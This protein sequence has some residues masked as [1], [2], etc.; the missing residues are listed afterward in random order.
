[1]KHGDLWKQFV[2]PDNAYRMA[3]LMRVNDAVTREEALR[4]V[5]SLKKQGCGGLFTYCEHLADQAPFRFLSQQWWAAVKVFAEACVKEGL[6]FWAYDEQDWPSGT[7]GGQLVEQNPEMGWKYVCPTEQD[8]EGPT[9]ARIEIGDGTLVAALAFRLDGEAVIEGSVRDLAEQVQSRLLTWNVPA[10]RWRVAVYTQH[11]GQGGALV[12]FS[13]DLMDPV[14][15]R[16]FIGMSYKGYLEAVRRVRG[17]RIAGYFTDEPIFSMGLYPTQRY[18]PTRPATAL[19]WTPGLLDA[20]RAQHGYDL[21]PKLPYLYYGGK[22]AVPTRCHYFQTCSRL[23]CENYFGQIYRFCEETGTLAT[24]HLNGEEV[25]ALH[26]GS[27]G[28]NHLMHYRYMHI[29]GIDWI[30]PRSIPLPSV[31]PK[32]AASIAHLMGRDRT[33][34]ESFAGSGW[35]M[36]FQEMRGIVNWE[37]VNGINM[38]IPISYKYSLRG[39]QRTTFYNPGISYQQPYWDHFRAFAD[40]EARLCAITAGGGHVAQVAL[41]YPAADMQAHF[42]ESDLLNQRSKDYNDLGDR[43]R[44]AGYDFDILDDHIVLEETGVE[45]GCLETA[46]ESFEVLVVPQM[47]AFRRATLEKVRGFVLAGGTLLFVG[48]LPRHSVESGADDPDLLRLLVELLSDNCHGRMAA[49]D[50]RWHTCGAGRV[51]MAPDADGAVTLLRA[52]VTPDVQMTPQIPGIVASHRRLDDGDLYL[53]HNH[54]DQPCAVRLTLAAKGHPERWDPLTGEAEGIDGYEVGDNGT[55]L[56]LDLQAQELVPVFLHADPAQAKPTTTATLLQAIPVPGPFRFRIEET[57]W[58]PEIAWNFSDVQREWTSNAEPLDVPES[59]GAGDWCECGLRCFSGIGHY[60]TE[61]TLEAMPAGTRVVLS[62][63]RVGVSAE[64]SV[65]GKRAGF[66]LFDPYEIDITDRVTEG[67]NRLTI[68]VANTLAN[69]YSQFAELAG[70]EHFEG[71]VLPEHLA[72]GLIGPVSLKM[73]ERRRPAGLL[74]RPPSPVE[75]ESLAVPLDDRLGLDD[76]Q[77]RSPSR[78]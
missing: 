61:V 23:F 67:R 16:T 11:L 72:S 53:V 10:G 7:C 58:R 25:F 52:L 71:G 47:D 36:T 70:K 37:H 26:L 66:V 64:V 51:G 65:N 44:Y 63:G 6:D 38:Q 39:P 31:S 20:F 57:L 19:A 27:Q 41:F 34:C 69:Y 14:V 48:S 56:R 9:T 13:S 22:E 28:G 77:G 68:S 12:P 2:S 4:Q 50:S 60:E 74:A 76:G 42:R 75:P 21:R 15:C 62:L 54:S 40:Y 45:S 1:M 33:W 43:L 73:V 30:L 3:P 78:P 35:G 18:V 49:G 32:Y 8:F 5:R 29:P 17:A 24:G 55:T 46:T 59:I